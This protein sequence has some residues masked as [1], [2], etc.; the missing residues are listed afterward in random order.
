LDVDNAPDVGGEPQA[1]AGTDLVPAVAGEPSPA[2]E[3]QAHTGPVTDPAVDDSNSDDSNDDD[4]NSDDPSTV[5]PGGVDPTDVGHADDPDPD[6]DVDVAIPTQRGTAVP[7]VVAP[8]STSTKVFYGVGRTVIAL[9]ATAVLAVTG[10]N[11]NTLH[12]LDKGIARTDVFDQAGTAPVDPV[13]DGV[14]PVVVPPLTSDLNILL[15]GMDSRTDPHGNPLPANELAMLHAGP[16]TGELDTDTMIL[17]HIPAGGQQAVAISF[18]RDSYVQLAGGFGKHRLNSAFAYAHNAMA[19]HL[20]A[21]GMTDAAQVEQQADT[22]GRKNLIA[23]IENL[24]GNAVTINRYAEINLVGFYQMSEAV[25]GVEVCLNHATHDSYTG[26]SFPAGVQTI[27]GVQALNFVRQ[28]HGLTNGDLDRITRQQ[29][30]LGALADKML[31]AGTLTSPSKIEQLTDA[32]QNSVT[33][34]SGWDVTSFAEQM[35]NLSSGAIQFHTI[36][37]GPDV[38]EGGADVIRI[39]PDDVQQFVKGLLDAPPPTSDLTTTPPTTPPT[40]GVPDSASRA[41]SVTTTTPTTSTS[42]PVDTDA[43]GPITANGIRCV[44]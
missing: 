12:N 15:V 10:Y 5:K 31:S 6:E 39:E 24:I 13:N 34:S 14:A 32:I 20:R 36:P 33:L 28:R 8:R 18:P 22:A 16:D 35:Q 2:T 43:T 9:A 21:A 1:T 19:N 3:P 42:L 23:T 4:S 40:T 17:L 37:T 26:A 25:G 44:N 29:V 11:W 7:V 38:V 41:P 30:F 27:S